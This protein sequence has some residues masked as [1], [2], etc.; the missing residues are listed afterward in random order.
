MLA[1]IKKLIGRKSI[2]KI[3]P[4]VVI[5]MELLGMLGILTRV[6][7]KAYIAFCD[8]IQFSSKH[9]LFPIQQLNYMQ[10]VIILLLL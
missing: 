3:A 6:N 8:N 1:S 7:I 10:L 2:L 9:C 4:S 5:N